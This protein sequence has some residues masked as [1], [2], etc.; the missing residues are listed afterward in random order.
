M[1]IGVVNDIL[2][3]LYIKVSLHQSDQSIN[4]N[5]DCRIKIFVNRIEYTFLIG[6][7]NGTN[8]DFINKQH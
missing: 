8:Y 1:L 4:D 2:R 7:F 3:A 5:G 6:M